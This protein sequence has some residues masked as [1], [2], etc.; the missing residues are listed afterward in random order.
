MAAWRYEISLLVLK[1]ISQVSATPMKYL[2][3]F[4]YDLEKVLAI[5]FK[6]QCLATNYLLIPAE[7][8]PNMGSKQ[9]DCPTK[10]LHFK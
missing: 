9:F 3:R 1:N 5:C 2:E 8:T 6:D 10:V 7:E 4:S